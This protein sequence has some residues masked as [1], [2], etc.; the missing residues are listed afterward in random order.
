MQF[1]SLFQQRR[2]KQQM[3]IIKYFKY[4][5]NDHFVLALMFL[6]G[7]AGYQYSNWVK[8]LTGPHFWLE[9]VLALVLTVITLIGGLATYVQPADQLFLLPLESKWRSYFE[10]AI[11]YSLFLP[12][13]LIVLAIMASFPFL[14]ATKNFGLGQLSVLGL[15]LMFLK[16]FDMLG[17]FA[18]LKMQTETT[19]RNR[20]LY[21]LALIF[22]T[23]IIGLSLNVWLG[24]LLAVL[25]VVG[26]ILLDRRQMTKEFQQWDWEIV[27]ATEAKRQQAMLRLISMFVDV[28]HKAAKAQRRKYLDALLI[29]PADQQSPYAYLYSRAFWRGNQLFGLWLR[30]TIIGI[31]VI[32]VMPSN[33]LAIIMVIFVQYISHFQL[34]PLYKQYDQHLLLQTYPINT[35]AKLNGFRQFLRGPLIIQL[36]IFTLSFLVLNNVIY[37]LIYLVAGYVFTYLFNTLYVKG[38]LK[39]KALKRTRKK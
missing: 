22:I 6:L 39:Q 8:T 18:H 33:W 7:A 14:V 38:R 34:L 27:T 5:F 21:S 17:R 31:I 20:R 3:R 12:L 25:A 10:K 16:Y 19:R 37:G 35:E 4:I 28:P 15:Q 24:L 13:L 26:Q 32:T 11:V 9:V 1:D 30:L 29:K 2:Q 36:G 23:L